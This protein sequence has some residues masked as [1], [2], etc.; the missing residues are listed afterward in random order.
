MKGGWLSLFIMLTEC[1]T[2]MYPLAAVFKL[3]APLPSRRFP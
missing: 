3:M 2:S 1:W